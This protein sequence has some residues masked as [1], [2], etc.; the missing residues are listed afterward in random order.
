LLTR[1]VKS[2]EHLNKISFSAKL[3]VMSLD[4]RLLKM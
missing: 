3:E 1:P 4:L 2:Q